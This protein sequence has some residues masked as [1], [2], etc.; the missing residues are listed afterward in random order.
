MVSAETRVM[1][2]GDGTHDGAAVDFRV[3]VRVRVKG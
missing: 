3:R 2:G 1:P